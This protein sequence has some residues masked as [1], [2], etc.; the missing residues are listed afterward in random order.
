MTAPAF[1]RRRLG[2]PALMGGGLAL[3][4]AAGYGFLALSGHTLPTGDAAAIASLYLLINIIGP[5][6]FTAVEQEASRSISSGMAADVVR[7]RATVAGAGLLGLVVVL[8]LA[9]S[10]VLVPEAFGGRWALF[11][12][13]VLGSATSAAVYL[14][15]GLLGGQRRFGGY[16]ATLAFEGVG[17][18]L[19]CILV[20]V[21][22]APG[23]AAYGLLFAA[24]SAVGVLAGLPAL[25]GGVPGNE[26][27]PERSLTAMAAAIAVLAGATVLAQLVAN[28]APVIVSA[29]LD[30]DT[31]TA[32]AFASAFVLVRIPLFLFA[33][34]QA[35]LLPTLTAAA[36]R[37]DLADFRR[38]LR[39]ILTSVAV[40]GA[41]GVAVSFALGPW[42]LRVFFGA[43][44][45]LPGVLLGWL[46]LGTV[47]LMVA[48]VLQPAL[49][50]L[51][52]HRATTLS[53]LLG[54]VALTGLL[55]LPGDP[56][57]IAVLAQLTGSVLVVA[58]MVIAARTALRGPVK[59]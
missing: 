52:M 25:R 29:R 54:S 19:P 31:A 40:V 47:A 1:A 38:K 23:S 6:V 34:V 17:R 49:V 18:L 2:P 11:A 5:G 15:R 35:L 37:G 58:G 14:V 10:P 8:L 59:R 51:G 36:T 16:A 12:A 9:V 46:A 27:A 20:A 3:V 30:E 41:V 53:W 21:L 48:Q 55:F 28:L 43:R 13:L 4:G 7:R 45:A 50:A 57:D 22:A 42:A 24:G 44:V 56:V 32:A 33:P 39:L 26:G